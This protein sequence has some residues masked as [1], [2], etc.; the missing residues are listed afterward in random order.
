MDKHFSDTVGY[1]DM[2]LQPPAPCE[3]WAWPAAEEQRVAAAAGGTN[4]DEHLPQA[5]HIEADVSSSGLAVE[6]DSV[7]I[8]VPSEATPSGPQVSP[9]PPPHPPPPPSSQV[10][11][12]PLDDI[13][14][15]E[16]C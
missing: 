11:E 14:V 9:P 3:A 5:S 8:H 1:T 4:S 12:L 7:A 10:V 13:V 6:S 16:L 2:P 15:G